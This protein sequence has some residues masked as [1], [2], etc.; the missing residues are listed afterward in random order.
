MIGPRCVPTDGSKE[1]AAVGVC[2]CVELDGRS[3]QLLAGFAFRDVILTRGGGGGGW[4]RKHAMYAL[5]CRNSF[6][7]ITVHGRC[8]RSWGK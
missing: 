2:R 8:G 6:P 5:T 4:Q 7:L 3:N 1:D